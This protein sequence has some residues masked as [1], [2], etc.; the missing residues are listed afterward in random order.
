MHIIGKKWFGPNGS[1]MNKKEKKRKQQA[2]ARSSYAQN[3]PL[4]TNPTKDEFLNSYEWRVV[5][6]RVLKRDGA[7]CQCCG[8]SAKDGSRMNVDHIK[9]RIL[10][11]Q[12]A[13]DMNN[14]QVLCDACNHGKSN[15]DM[16]DWRE[17]EKFRRAPA[18]SKS[19]S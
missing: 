1:R 6:M 7:K 15:W 17:V 5:R 8:A 2:W 4:R 19:N 11:P 18:G 12:L 13:L 16:T 3:P 10:F 14:L 9:P